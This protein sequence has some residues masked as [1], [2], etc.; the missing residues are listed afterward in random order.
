MVLT[1]NNRN[2]AS[3]SEIMF[4]DSFVPLFTICFLFVVLMGLVVTSSIFS[5]SLWF[6]CRLPHK[7]SD[8]RFGMRWLNLWPSNFL[9]WGL[10][11]STHIGIKLEVVTGNDGKYPRKTVILFLQKSWRRNSKRSASRLTQAKVVKKK[12]RSR[13]WINRWLPWKPSLQNPKVSESPVYKNVIWLTDLTLLSSTPLLVT[14]QL[15]IWQVCQSWMW[16]KTL[17]KHSE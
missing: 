6:N 11:S 2:R 10:R 17:L 9:K 1:S 16:W 13:L 3:T 15:S 14:S 7:W 5:P 12:G 4:I 8:I